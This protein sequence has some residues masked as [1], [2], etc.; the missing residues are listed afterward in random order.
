MFGLLNHNHSSRRSFR[1]PANCNGSRTLRLEMLEGRR[2]LSV[3]GPVS[4]SP[5]VMPSVQVES[6]YWGQDWTTGTS[7]APG[8]SPT[9]NMQAIDAFL[10]TIVNSRYMD[11]SNQ[12]GVSR[13]S[14]V[15]RDVAAGGPTDFQPLTRL[16]ALATG[17]SPV[18]GPPTTVTEASIQQMLDN[19]IHQGRLTMGPNKLFVVVLPPD[20]QSAYDIA[21][22]YVGHHGGF[23]DVS[24]TTGLFHLPIFTNV[25]Y[26]VIPNPIGNAKLLGALGTE[27]SFQYQTEVISHELAE[28]VTDPIVNGTALGWYDRNTLSPTWGDEIG[29]IPQYMVTTG[30]LKNC[31]GS[32]DG[33]MLSDIWSN[34]A[35]TAVLPS[36]LIVKN[37]GLSVIGPVI[38]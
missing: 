23:V 11:L 18:H 38:I 21:N 25:Y 16:S 35:N 26:A 10:G 28:A 12:Y 24:Y 13:G 19:E 36:N 4:G 31:V 9:A 20:V 1:R 34:Q 6:V 5:V 32:Y 37:P 2:L 15:G 14:F 8:F 33:Y 7:P 29:D 27:T 22:N 17:I 30:Q 3:S